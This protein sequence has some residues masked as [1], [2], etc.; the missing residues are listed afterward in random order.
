[1]WEWL[2]DGLEFKHKIGVTEPWD[3]VGSVQSGAVF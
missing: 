2:V 1:M 3:G